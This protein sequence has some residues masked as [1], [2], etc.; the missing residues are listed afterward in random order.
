MAKQLR[1]SPRT[2]GQEPS[3]LLV[4]GAEFAEDLHVAGVGGLAVDDVVTERAP[5]QLLA[6][7]GVLHA[8]ESHPAERLGELRRPEPERLDLLA[9]R[10]QIG[11]QLREGPRQERRLERIDL[12]LHEFA[13]RGQDRCMD[14]GIEKSIRQSPGQENV[15]ERIAAADA[16]PHHVTQ[17]A[18]QAEVVALGFREHLDQLADELADLADDLG[19]GRLIASAR[20]RTIALPTIR[21]SAT[22]A[23]WRTWSGPLIPNPMQ[24]GRSVWV[25]SQPTVSTRSDGRLFRSPVIPATET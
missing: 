20:R 15:T 14:S 10:P 9:D 13:D 6:D 1:T 5:A 7:Q 2:N 8:I 25:R 4:V 3:L 24:I 17:H 23:S 19:A 18:G 21:P 12:A 11:H 16:R 22:G